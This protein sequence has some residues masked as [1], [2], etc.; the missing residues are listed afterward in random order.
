MKSVPRL[1]WYADVELRIHGY[2]HE[3][4]VPDA[5]QRHQ[6]VHPEVTHLDRQHRQTRV[7]L[8]PAQQRSAQKDPVLD[9]RGG[10]KWGML[11]GRLQVK[12][13]FVSQSVSFVAVPP[14]SSDTLDKAK[15][16]RVG[17][18]TRRSTFHLV[19]YDA[20]PSVQRL[21]TSRSS[22]RSIWSIASRAVRRVPSNARP[23]SRLARRAPPPCASAWGACRPQRAG[24]R[25]A[26][27]RRAQPRPG[28]ADRRQAAHAR[29]YPPPRL[30]L[31]PPAHVRSRASNSRQRPR[32]RG[33]IPTRA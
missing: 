9:L 15:Y 18:K 23:S 12:I 19:F 32:G 21:Q 22:P 1:T 33:A 29:H 28:R 7:G 13:N 24:N 16:S 4:E 30:S 3:R 25:I 26:A 14:R 5:V 6:D 17:N 11:G 20:A 31:A 27:C 2:Q 8:L 10:G